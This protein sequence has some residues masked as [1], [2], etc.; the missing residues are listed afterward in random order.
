MFQYLKFMS[1]H[2]LALSIAFFASLGGSTISIALGSWLVLFILADTVFGDDVTEPTYKFP[3]FLTSQ[4]WMALPLMF[5][6]TFVC[7]W[8]FASVDVFSYGATFQSLTGI[9]ILAARADTHPIH[10]VSLSILLALSIGLISTLVGHELTHRT[11]DPVSMLIGRWLLAFSFDSNFAIEHVYGHHRYVSTIDD[12][13]TAPRGRNVY[14][15]LFIS[16]Y[17]CNVGSWVIEGERL[18]KKGLGLFSVHNLAIRGYLMSIALV[19][20]AYYVAGWQ[21][22]VF[23]TISAIL[24]KFVLEIVNFMEHYGMVRN[25]EV[26]VQP[27]HSWN[28]NKR[29]SSWVMFNLTRHSHHHAQGEVPYQDLKPYADAPMMVG[30]YLTTIVATLIPPLW[31]KLMIPKVLAWDQKYASDEE[32]QLANA[33]NKISGLPAFEAVQYKVKPAQQKAA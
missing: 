31:N 20:G 11:W 19:V 4:L 23:F 24:G 28:T 7:V 2:A 8:Q 30:G 26:P 13:A 6:V 16:T 9:D 32:L 25:P 17:R 5:L 21:G 27:Y 29:V 15:H 22:A 3:Q 10:Y 14:A 33:A 18:K 12:P 1:F